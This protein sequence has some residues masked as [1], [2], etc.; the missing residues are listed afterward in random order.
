MYKKFNNNGI[1]DFDADLIGKLS[2]VGRKSF[3]K[4]CLKFDGIICFINDLSFITCLFFDYILKFGLL[5][6]GH[7]YKVLKNIYASK[8]INDFIIA[9]SSSN[10]I[11][12]PGKVALVLEKILTVMVKSELFLERINGKYVYYVINFSKL[13]K[14]ELNPFKFDSFIFKTSFL[15]TRFTKLTS[16]IKNIEKKEGFEL[17]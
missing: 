9:L 2:S 3:S 10:S 11:D 1:L 16:K 14:L 17:W 15:N 6:K 5:I 12:E 7:A 4:E 13:K 8:G